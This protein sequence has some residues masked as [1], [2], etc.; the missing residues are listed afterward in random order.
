MFLM[1][2]LLLLLIKY[3][4]LLT[5]HKNK[6]GFLLSVVLQL[7]HMEEWEVAVKNKRRVF[8]LK[9]N[10]MSGQSIRIKTKAI[11]T[12][13]WYPNVIPVRG[14]ISTQDVLVTGTN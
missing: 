14:T 9:S 12:P 7:L 3:L 1:R 8:L 6:K 5:W 10:L 11:T 2:P 4:I 13:T